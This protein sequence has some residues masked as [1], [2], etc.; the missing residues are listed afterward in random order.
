MFAVLLV[1][2]ILSITLGILNIAMKEFNFTSTAKNSHVSFFAAD[3]GGEC[4][5]Y[6]RKL[7]MLED[8]SP[9]M[10]CDT[11]TI[12]LNGPA[13]SS[14]GVTT[15]QFM[16]I[17]IQDGCAVVDIVL[18]NSDSLVTRTTINS[19][20]YNV[21]C[22]NLNNSKNKVERLLSYTFINGENGGGGTGTTGGTS[23]TTNTTTIPIG[24]ITPINP[25]NLTGGMFN[26]GGTSA[27]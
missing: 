1:S 16:P 22:A 24:T 23:T 19:H 21:T 13:V 20:G 8:A 9:T 14:N 25:G 27:N 15:F 3:T 18:D 26:N 17:A 11:Q 2:I 6:G 7:G 10:I 4:A 12:G 5:M